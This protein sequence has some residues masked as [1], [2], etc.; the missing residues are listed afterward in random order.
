MYMAEESSSS[1][2]ASVAIVLLVIAA[3]FF[4]VRYFAGSQGASIKIEAPN[5]GK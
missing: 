5:L 3:L 2:V 1:A 4:G